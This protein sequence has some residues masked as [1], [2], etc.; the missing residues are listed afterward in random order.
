MSVYYTAVWISPSGARWNARPKD[1]VWCAQLVFARADGETDYSY[2]YADSEEEP[3]N[4]DALLPDGATLLEIEIS[5]CRLL[6][7]ETW[8]HLDSD[9]RDISSDPVMNMDDVVEKRIWNPGGLVA[10][11]RRD[12]ET[13]WERIA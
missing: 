10:A 5:R 12:G 4:A 7:G 13:R 9:G 6:D 11:W 1:A 3:D 8:Q 2:G